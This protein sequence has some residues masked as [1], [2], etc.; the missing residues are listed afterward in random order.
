MAPER[1]LLAP[2]YIVELQLDATERYLLVG[3]EWRNRGP[4]WVRF[5]IYDLGSGR[6][7]FEERH[8]EGD[9]CREPRITAGP[10]GHVAFSYR[11]ESKMKRTIVHYRLR[12]Q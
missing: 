4:H 1:H 3:E 2:I 11:N 12:E 6:R 5:S 10:D 8:G 7:I 9:S